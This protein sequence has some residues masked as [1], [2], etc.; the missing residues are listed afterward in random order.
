MLHAPSAPMTAI[1]AVG[2]ARLTSAPML[3]EFMTMYAPP[4][5][6]L[7]MSVTFGTVA[8][9]NAY[10]IFAPCRMM[11]LCSCRTPGRNPGTSSMATS[12]ML[13]QS[14]NRMN[15]AALSLASMS[16]AP[17][18]WFGWL[19][20]NPTVLPAILP[21]PI[22]MFCANCS[23][24]S[25]KYCWSQMG[26]MMLRMSYGTL[27][28]AGTTW[29]SSWHTRV[30]SSVTGCVGGSSMLFDGMNPMSSL[31]VM[32][33]SSSSLHMK[34]LTPLSVLCVVAPP[35]VSLSTSSF[36]TALTTF[37]PVT[38]IW[39]CLLTMSMKSVSAGE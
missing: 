22:T 14:Q 8:S 1:S 34:W 7:V 4:Y 29:S 37:G 24:I 27:G 32:S 21:N 20:T 31:M 23:C 28:S 6:F 30:S 16:S 39:L 11:P 36:V 5:A 17:A 25:K 3:F 35:S 15:R 2:Y 38:N 12:G 18:R 19:A 13:K 26:S 10:T 33:V 9:A